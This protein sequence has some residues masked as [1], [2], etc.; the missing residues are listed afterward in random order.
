[1]I[2]LLFVSYFDTGTKKYSRNN[3]GENVLRS[4]KRTH[5][6]FTEARNRGSRFLE[7]WI[8]NRRQ[9]AATGG[10]RRQPAATGGNRR[11]I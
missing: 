11:L 6:F 10:N 8:F 4:R 1:L 9:P 5:R 7:F 2:P 3:R